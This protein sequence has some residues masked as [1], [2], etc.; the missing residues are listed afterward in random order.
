MDNDLF[1]IGND[2]ITPN[3]NRD[4]NSPPSTMSVRSQGMDNGIKFAMQFVSFDDAEISVAT[5]F[6]KSDMRSD[7]SSSDTFSCL[8]TELYRLE[9]SVSTCGQSAL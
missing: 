6:L 8:V 4:G 9:N 7:K 1:V 2:G 3:N 5:Y